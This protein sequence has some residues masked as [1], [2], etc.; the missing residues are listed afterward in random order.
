MNQRILA[1]Q[2]EW[3]ESVRVQAK[4]KEESGSSPLPKIFLRLVKK[5]DRFE[6]DFYLRKI[7]DRSRR[8]F[9]CLKATLRP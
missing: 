8:A 7:G 6:A 3:R 1:M 5:F 9:R 4:G 2:R